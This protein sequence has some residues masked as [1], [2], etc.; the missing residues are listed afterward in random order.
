MIIARVLPDMSTL[1]A[2]SKT[3]CCWYIAA[4]PHLH[5]TL[6]LSQ[7]F[8]DPPRRG[9]IQLQNLGKMRLLP[10]FKRL[11][12]VKDGGGL[13]PPPMI[14]NTQSFAYFSALTNVQELGLDKVDLAVLAPQAQQH[15]GHFAPTL[16]SI[17]LVGPRGAR[18]QLLRFL[19]LFPNLDDFS[20]I[21]DQVHTFEPNPEPVPRSALP[22]RGRLALKMFY[23]EEFLRALSE[24]SDGLRF[25]HMDLL[26]AEGGRFLMDTCAATLETLRIHPVCWIGEGHSHAFQSSSV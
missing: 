23:G 24:L 26:E 2:C 19:G 8:R 11:Q 13:W 12:I 5:H 4:L 7:C 16:R 25:R 15:F 6:T 22:L 21:D 10:L 9:L 18:S 20:L 17:T 14:P 3:C 1:K